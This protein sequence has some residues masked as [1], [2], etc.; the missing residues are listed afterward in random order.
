M[1]RLGQVLT[2][3]RYAED[4]ERSSPTGDELPNTTDSREIGFDQSYSQ[5][6]GKRPDYRIFNQLLYEMTLFFH[7]ANQHGL[8]PPWSADI[9]YIDP[10]FVKGRDGRVYLSKADSGPTTADSIDPVVDAQNTRWD[11]Y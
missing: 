3:P 8:P 10:A 5:V 9:D 6:G 1:A 4:G 2:I 11:V 7:H